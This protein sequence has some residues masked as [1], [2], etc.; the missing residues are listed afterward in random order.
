MKKLKF[1]KDYEQVGT[2]DFWYDLT[3]GGYIKPKDFLEEEDAKRVKAAVDLLRQFEDE[4]AE[5]DIIYSL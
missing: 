2:D 3:R 1:K 5:L 4:A